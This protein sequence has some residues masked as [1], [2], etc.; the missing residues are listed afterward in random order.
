MRLLPI[1][2]F[3]LSC[4]V[5]LPTLAEQ[6]ARC[7]D[8]ILQ[9]GERCDD[10]NE[11]PF[12]ACLV[13]CEFARC[14]D[15]F[16]RTDLAQD[17]EGFEQC[18]DGNFND[19]DGCT[20]TCELARCGDGLRR[21]D[22]TAGSQSQC[23]GRGSD[24]CPQGETC[25]GG[26]C[27]AANYEHCDD[28]NQDDDD[29]C[30]RDCLA[31]RCGDRF[32]QTGEVC[33]DGNCSDQDV[34]LSNCTA[35]VCGDGFLNEGIEECED[36][37]TL[38][39]DGCDSQCLTEACG[40][41]RVDQ[42]EEC[43]SVE[44]TTV[45]AC[46]DCQ[47][48][49]CGDGQLYE[50]REACDDG[51]LEPGDE[52]SI[53]CRLDD[54]GDNFETA[55][56]L[57]T[58][59]YVSAGL[60]HPI[61]DAMIQSQQDTDVFRLRANVA[62]V[63]MLFVRGGPQMDPS[64]R[65]FSADGILAGFQDDQGRPDR[66]IDPIL[67]GKSLDCNVEIHLEVGEE[68]FLSV[69]GYGESAGPYDVYLATPCGNGL[70]DAGEE[71]DPA[72]EDSNYYRCRDDCRSRRHLA[73]AG[74]T[75]CVVVD[76]SVNCWGSNAALV[77]GDFEN[78]EARDQLQCQ[79]PDGNENQRVDA[80]ARPIRVIQR[81]FRVL[82][83]SGGWNQNICAL[84]GRDGHAYCWG[85]I[86]NAASE[87]SN[88]L[89]EAADWQWCAHEP[90]VEREPWREGR[91]F[92][93]GSCLATP[94]V[95]GIGET[96]GFPDNMRSV[97]GVTVGSISKCLISKA[98]ENSP[99]RAQCWGGG[100]N[101]VL[102]VNYCP[103]GNCAGLGSPFPIA[104]PENKEPIY[105]ALG[106]QT[107]CGIL[108]DGRLV[109]WGRNDYGQT[110]SGLQIEVP[111]SCEVRCDLTP[112]YVDADLQ[113]VI[114]VAVGGDHACALTTGGGL[115]CWGRNDSLQ[116]GLD[117]DEAL[118]GGVACVRRPRRIP[119]L[120]GVVDIAL[121]EKHS[122]VLS[123]RGEIFCWG[124]NEQGQL[125]MG[126]IG[127]I[128]FGESPNLQTPVRVG[129]IPSVAGLTAGRNSNCARTDQNRVFCWGANETGQLGSG[130]CGDPSAFPIE[131]ELDL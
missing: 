118:C 66:V 18:D 5:N 85:R 79:L 40:N 20:N 44:L 14:G 16:Q 46:V 9:E 57:A 2:T 119:D 87:V 76:G 32:V 88:D 102:G 64:C 77:L 42:G 122:C 33:D 13:T 52:C 86:G 63:F 98:G 58:A 110:G 131:V 37:N 56:P 112:Q 50:G 91:G 7:G 80:A 89:I 103:G 127:P 124:N 83:I 34:C 69:R 4:S 15:G 116:T 19:R 31:P 121:G 90:Q 35:A 8:G 100:T 27:W 71:C 113:N 17:T 29:G 128:V 97:Q 59:A 101:G 125:G 81:R 21:A 107:G 25:I 10:G 84:Y 109:C 62:G 94:T 1:L 111:D 67:T 114:H 106:T 68:A 105:I 82:D 36:G 28:G 129:R 24:I 74:G 43:D 99:F 30:T 48:G 126:T 123:Q 3:C 38:S 73:M 47:N 11:D 120:N 6:V 75:S 54:H 70:P 22:V 65:I 72:S 53:D 115:W 117:S 96:L 39:G 130:S 12:D 23:C 95:Y 49:R 51:N 60:E 108:S 104:M 41:G 55:T 61:A 45:G 92:T 26:L 78:V 93:P